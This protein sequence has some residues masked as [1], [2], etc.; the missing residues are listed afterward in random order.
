MC[1]TK[2]LGQFFLLEFEI[3]EIS[4]IFSVEQPIQNCVQKKFKKKVRH[5]VISSKLSLMF[6]NCFF[7]VNLHQNTINN[8]IALPN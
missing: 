6:V 1:C 3:C 8:L 4:V 7:F 5:S 2:K